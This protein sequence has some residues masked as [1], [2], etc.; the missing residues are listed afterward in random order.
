MDACS[1]A[2]LLHFCSRFAI[3]ISM[4]KKED[5]TSKY[6]WL[7]AIFLILVASIGC[8]SFFTGF[9]KWL[10]SELNEG[11]G[12]LFAGLIG[13]IGL[14]FVAWWSGHQTKEALIIS[15]NL[16]RELEK[17]RQEENRKLEKE[18]HDE[19]K[20]LETQKRE[21]ATAE[22]VQILSG[23]LGYERSKYDRLLEMCTEDISNQKEEITIKFLRKQAQDMDYFSSNFFNRDLTIFRGIEANIISSCYDVM[24]R[25]DAIRTL[26][27]V[28]FIQASEQIE[29]IKYHCENLI[30]KIDD[31]T[32]RLR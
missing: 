14:I 19:T 31:I 1:Y 30:K 9:W 10:N 32:S 24:V 7:F 2:S 18:R 29:N 15:A 13:F 6:Y 27:G 16:D 20:A 26:I 22:N 11:L 23:I 17:D 8:V 28:D 5:K 25:I 21:Q 4:N 3:I 12:A